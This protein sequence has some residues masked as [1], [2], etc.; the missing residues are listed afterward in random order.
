MSIKKYRM[1]KKYILQ[2]IIYIK[3]HNIIA[4]SKTVVRT[5]FH[6]SLTG[7]FLTDLVKPFISLETWMKGFFI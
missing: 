2:L 6:V 5:T 3:N 7:L 4:S 1:L